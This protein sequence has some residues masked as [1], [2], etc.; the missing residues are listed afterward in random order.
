MIR[1]GLEWTLFDTPLSL[2][3]V[4]EPTVIPD[5][6]LRLYAK[7][8]AGVSAL[9]Y[10]GDDE[11][12]HDL[13]GS[14]LG[15][16]AADQVAFWTATSTLSGDA[17]LIYKSA[18]DRLGI[19]SA[20]SPDSG[21][22]IKKAGGHAVSVDGESL[23]RFEGTS[24][25]AGISIGSVAGQNSFLEFLEATTKKAGVE[26]NSTLGQL[27]VGSAGSGGNLLLQSTSHPTKS[28]ILFGTSAYDEVNNRLGVGN[29]SPSDTLHVGD[30]ESAFAGFFTFNDSRAHIVRA[31]MGSGIKTVLELLG[32]ANSSTGGGSAALIIG[33]DQA[34]TDTVNCID[35]TSYTSN[36]ALTTNVFNAGLNAAG[37]HYGAGAADWV[38]GGQYLAR[39]TNYGGPATGAVG[40]MSGIRIHSNL[41]SAGATITENYGLR[42]ES[43][44]VG[45]S[46]WQIYSVGTAPS[47]FAGFIGIGDPAPIFPLYAKRVASDFLSQI[48]IENSASGAFYVG[49]AAVADFS[50]GDQ[51]GEEF[52]NMLYLT[53]GGSGLTIPT[54][55]NQGY[56][57]TGNQVLQGM[58]IATEY[59]PLRFVTHSNPTGAEM[60][61][62]TS[63]KFRVGE[64]GQWGIGGSATSTYNTANFGAAGNVMISGGPS[65]ATSWFNRLVL[66]GDNMILGGG[67]TA[68]EFRFLEPSG[69]GTNYSAFKAQAQA[70]NM[71]YTL[72]AQGPTVDNQVLASTIAGVL[73]WVT[74][75]LV[76]NGAYF[77]NRYFGGRY[78]GNRYF[79]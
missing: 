63:E 61:P 27:E 35:S 31:N 79:D 33:I 73:S 78:F 1:E 30:L 62:F 57:S 76:V 39:A 46:D 69:S 24:S 9:F 4:T 19:G 29:A 51:D 52:I 21:L 32:T 34:G 75:T 17:G 26:W 70:G 54:L 16:G 59:G 67:T 41:N 10:K 65:A 42:I 48:V 15:S 56:I 40:K 47:Y 77:G 45:V 71:T 64:L 14:L 38:I 55:G 68:S 22:H 28:K 18:T 60:V 25:Y 53:T 44:T 5:N 49:F 6:S 13:S 11:V 12:E 23:A 2:E 50:E 7:D 74:A 8:K 58:S 20:S 66:S 37:E 43:Q 72:P 36:P 3:E